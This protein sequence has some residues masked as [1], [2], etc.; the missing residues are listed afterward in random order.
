VGLLREAL[1]QVP[2]SQRLD[3][4]RQS[5]EAEPALAALRGSAGMLRLERTVA[6]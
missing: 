6:R 2:E 5:V 3:F 4:W 1:A